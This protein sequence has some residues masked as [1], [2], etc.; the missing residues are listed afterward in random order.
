MPTQT[1]RTSRRASVLQTAYGS[2]RSIPG[3]FISLTQRAAPSISQA[4]SR[5]PLSPL[6]PLPQEQSPDGPRFRVIPDDD[7][8][9]GDERPDTPVP[10]GGGGDD[11]NGD[12]P[13]DSPDD[14][15]D[16]TTSDTEQNFGA[17]NPEDDLNNVPLAFEPFA[18]LAD[19]IRNLTREA[20]RR[21]RN[22]DGPKTKVREPDPFDGSDP[23]K[24]RP[25]VVQCEINFQANPRS[26]RKERAKVTFAQSYLKG[27]ALEYFEPDLL[28]DQPPDLRP[29]WMDHW[30]Y[31]L[32]ELQTNFGP[33]DPVA[34]AEAQLER[35]QMRDGQRI[36]KYIVEW[37]RL[38][39]QV[40]DWGHG[41]LRRSFYNGLPDRIKDEISRQGKPD[42]IADLRSLSQKIDHR[43]WERKEEISRASKASGSTSG[44]QNSSSKSS[45]S[46]AN[47]SSSSSSKP[48]DE[49][50]KGSSSSASTSGSSGNGGN[51]NNNNKKGNSSSTPDSISSKL[52]KDGKLLPEERQ[53][54]LK[55]GLCLFCG[56]AGHSAK[57]CP[58]STSRA[59]KGR[60]AT[61]TPAVSTSGSASSE[62]KK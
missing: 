36:T 51:N 3:E 44:N 52:G 5:A 29:L 45:G 15:S 31:F 8:L 27:V 11:G 7:D 61:A 47:N 42:S 56:L 25:F 9:Y 60:A 33:H 54:R 35:L 58:K 43:Y 28:G 17:N 10:G 12:D 32:Y 50:S 21:K 1:T 40:R 24:L 26:F 57:E 39:S 34:D 41:A 16:T 20:L 48:K 30:D 53:R 4:W 19:A 59:A 38:A 23:K 18:Q 37:N 2:S 62:A 14:S 13:D 55:Q 46:N 49:K 6:T 22:T